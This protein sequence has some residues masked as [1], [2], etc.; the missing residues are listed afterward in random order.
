VS[1]ALFTI[2]VAIAAA[3]ALCV[4]QPDPASPDSVQPKASPPP[5][6]K[7]LFDWLIKPEPPRQRGTGSPAES[8]PGPG[9]GAGSAGQ[10]ARAAANPEAAPQA[11]APAAGLVSTVESSTN[12]SAAAM[13]S[14]VPLVAPSSVL[15]AAAPATGSA[16]VSALLSP[17]PA[18]VPATAE[19]RSGMALILPAKAEGFARAAEVTRKGFMAAR[20]LATDKP[21]IHV[22][23]TD[24]T[25]AG[26][27]AAYHEALAKNVA[28]VVGPLTKTEVAAL[29]K[30]P[31]PVPTLMLNT[32]DGAAVTTSGLYM[33][34]LSTE[35]EARYAAER[36]YRP[37]AGNAVIVA[38]NS[39]LSKRA[40]AAF[41]ESWTK[42]GGVVK[43]NIEFNG[44]LAK[45]KQG[46]DRAHGD[47]VFLA[48][49]ADRARLIKPFL[50]R[51]TAVIATSQV[52]SGAARTEAAGRVDSQK[53]ND[54]NGLRF[55]DMPWLH[56]PDH[57]ATMVFARPDPPLSADLERL[58]ALGIDAFR[59]A[60]QLSHQHGVFEIDGVTGRLAVREGLIERTPIQAEYREGL[61]VPVDGAMAAQRGTAYA[62]HAGSPSG[63]V[64]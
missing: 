35:L 17:S 19:A 30:E 3:P 64:R 25:A 57:P 8:L 10:P 31:I 53:V 36:A 11:S 6:L 28:V 27:I 42:L 62:A 14:A 45:I 37:E 5:P 12:A 16:A 47:I 39:P 26:A 60:E 63:E 34:S 48:A 41:L 24:G 50:G 38:T 1:A 54:L 59:V 20:E 49:D 29:Q 4:A 55:I 2:A 13:V 7:A 22:L 21:V 40:A 56:Q 23:E 58:Y 33:L 43:E 32:P 18:G 46:V 51:H 15:V 9:Y 44:N 61:A 52:Y